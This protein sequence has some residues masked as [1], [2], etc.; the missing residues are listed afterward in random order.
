M[1]NTD[2]DTIQQHP[3]LTFLRFVGK[4]IKWGF[5]ITLIAVIGFVVANG[6]AI[7]HCA[8]LDLNTAYRS[9][10]PVTMTD[11]S[12][13]TRII[14]GEAWL[15]LDEVP[16][17]LIIALV[18]A[19]DKRF[20]TREWGVDPWALLRS[21]YQTLTGNTM[22]GSTLHM[23]SARSGYDLPGGSMDRSL[24]RKVLEMIVAVR[25]SEKFSKEQI[26]EIYLNCANFAGEKGLK[27]AARKFFNC[28]SPRELTGPQIIWLISTLPRPNARAKEAN[29]GKALERVQTTANKIIL[30]GGYNP[31]DIG[32]RAGGQKLDFERGRMARDLPFGLFSDVRRTF[33]AEEWKELK[34]LGGADVE[35]TFD[36]ALQARLQ[37]TLTAGMASLAP[38]LL[39]SAPAELKAAFVVLDA[40]TGAVLACISSRNAHDEYS[41]ATQAQR[42]PG[43]TMKAFEFAVAIESGAERADTMVNDAPLA[44]GTLKGM[45]AGR[46]R[47]PANADGRYL[48]L[49][50]LADAF[51][52]SRNPVFVKLGD[53]HRAPLDTLLRAMNVGYVEADKPA[54]FIVGRPVTL[55][56]WTAAYAAFANNGVWHKPYMVK[57]VVTAGGSEAYAVKAE[58][59]R[60]MNSTTADEVYAAMRGVILEGTAHSLNWLP[61]V[62]KTGTTSADG[63]DR[64]RD[65]RFQYL[66]RGNGVRR[67]IAVGLWVGANKGGIENPDA[68]SR[69]VLSLAGRLI[70]IVRESSVVDSPRR[71]ITQVSR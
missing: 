23:Q 21:I 32:L 66:E 10:L 62:G 25:L 44:P 15:K 60:V 42:E 35:L 28:T 69:H 30:N 67:P 2:T 46:L 48:G 40:E 52:R 54:Q 37:E 51:A 71:A 18:A 63:G 68:T 33:S 29:T 61:G 20:W 53:A 6:S 58:T 50:T 5:I 14:E 31:T 7:H 17:E 11:A 36:L 4:S 38:L 56:E 26:L 45:P 12:G 65:L 1:N 64:A 13:T 19:E 47:W 3:R 9:R 43:S 41:F 55:M 39:P 70:K 8:T 24:T 34:M 27:A 22:G 59:K 16:K 57:R 49:M